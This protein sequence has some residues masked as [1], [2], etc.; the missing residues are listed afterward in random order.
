MRTILVPTDFSKNAKNALD[1]AAS[2]AKKENSKLILLHAFHI[3]YPSSEIPVAMVVEEVSGTQKKAEEEL[4]KLCLEIK[5]NKKLKCD[6][7]CREG[8]AV[9]ILLEVSRKIRPDLIIMGTKGASGIRE[10]ILGSNTAKVIEKAICPVIAVPAGASFKGIRNIVFSTDYHESD[11]NALKKTTGIAK[12]FGSRI[13]ILHASDREFTQE[14]EE[15][16][17]RQF[18]KTVSKKIKYSKISSLVK[19]GE[20]PE[21]ILQDYIKKKKPDLIAMSTQRRSLLE[22]LFGTSITKKMAYHTNVPL[23]AFHHKHESVV[24]I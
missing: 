17:M 13:N 5:K 3:F 1:Y 20:L 7:I 2:V 23:L 12:I 8:L 15:G 19:Y 16:L 4:N 11:V 10:V 9:D 24:F 22:K 18:M 21:N 14:V 6:F